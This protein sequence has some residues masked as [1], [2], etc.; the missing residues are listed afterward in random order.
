MSK[1]AF[2]RI[3]RQAIASA[4]NVECDVAEFHVGLAIIWHEVQERCEMEGVDP[5]A[6]DVL[7]ALDD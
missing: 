7:A 1:E 5:H 2:K 4:E 3:A 6:P